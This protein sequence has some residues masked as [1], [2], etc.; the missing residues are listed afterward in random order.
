MFHGDDDFSSGVSFCKVP[1]GFSNLSHWV[2]SI[3]DRYDFA[4]FKKLFNETQ[5]RL[6]GFLNPHETYLLTSDP[7]YQWPH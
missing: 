3:D 1:D 7:R 6:V 4:S 5:I 2:T